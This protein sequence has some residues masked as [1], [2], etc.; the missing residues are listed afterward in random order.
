MGQ[1]KPTA[2][3]KGIYTTIM[4][5][6]LLLLTMCREAQ[7]DALY[8]SDNLRI[9][10]LTTHTY[11]HISYMDTEKFGRVPCNG[12]VVFSDE[13]ALII[14]TPPG[15]I[16]SAEL[17]E[18]INGTLQVEILGVIS[19]HFHEDCL[20]GLAT[21]HEYK[22]P[23]YASNHTIKLAKENGYIPPKYGFQNSMIMNAGYVRTITQYFGHG[24]TPDNMVVYVPDDKVLF[25]GCLVKAV[26]AGPGNLEDANT[27][28]WPNTLRN[29][30]TTY[31][32]AAIV[33][34]GHGAPG[35]RELLEYTVGLFGKSQ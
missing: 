25:G 34:P 12:L 26:G 32:Q 5:L 21:F 14:D 9:E 4:L 6:P 23:S 24:H 18:W 13:E 10:Q 35:G 2:M 8:I 7:D 1:Y 33:V 20:G 11:L 29:V 17:L 16:A 27:V 30:I 15:D 3:M 31:P 22:I 28:I 19:T